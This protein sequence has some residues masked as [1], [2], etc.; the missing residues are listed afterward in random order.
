LSIFQLS[1]ENIGGK[2]GFYLF[3]K[4][5]E[6]LHINTSSKMSL[7]FI[8]EIFGLCPNSLKLHSFDDLQ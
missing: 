7:R 8:E 2:K 5:E 6:Y 4:I 1:A 3:R